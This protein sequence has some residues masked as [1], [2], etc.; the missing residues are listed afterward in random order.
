MWQKPARGSQDTH[1][2][3][4]KQIT[5]VYQKCRE[6]ARK[7]LAEWMEA[8]IVPP[9]DTVETCRLHFLIGWSFLNLSI[10]KGNAFLDQM[11]QLADTIYGY[12]KKHQKT[13]QTFEQ[14]IVKETQHF[15]HNTY[16]PINDNHSI[17]NKWSL[18]SQSHTHQPKKKRDQKFAAFTCTTLKQLENAK[19]GASE[20]LV[21]VNWT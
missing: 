21:Q 2:D 13:Q 19:S 18:W 12:A 14:L 7:H 20:L 17:D 5:S 3:V 11:A 4:K 6:S 15:Q 1:T 9:P 16:T 8:I 10:S